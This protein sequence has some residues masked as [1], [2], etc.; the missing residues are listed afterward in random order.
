[1]ADETKITITAG[2]SDDILKQIRAIERELAG[3]AAVPLWR[4]RDPAIAA[5]RKIDEDTD[6]KAQDAKTLYAIR[7][8]N[9]TY[10]QFIMSEGARYNDGTYGG[11]I[12]RNQLWYEESETFFEQEQET[13]KELSA[14]IKERIGKGIDRES[15]RGA[16]ALRYVQ[17]FEN[18]RRGMT[19]TPKEILEGY[20]PLAQ[21]YGKPFDLSVWGDFY[22]EKIMSVPG[23]GEYARLT[24]S[25]SDKEYLDESRRRD[26]RFG[27]RLFKRLGNTI[28]PDAASNIISRQEGV[29]RREKTDALYAFMTGERRKGTPRDFYAGWGSDTARRNNGRL[30]LTYNPDV[31]G[32]EGRQATRNTDA[33]RPSARPA[34]RAEQQAASLADDWFNEAAGAASAA[35]RP[36]EAGGRL[37]AA[38]AELSDAERGARGEGILPGAKSEASGERAKREAAFERRYDN[39]QAYRE[40]R[41]KRQESEKVHTADD[42]FYASQSMENIDFTDEFA[43]LD[44]ALLSGFKERR[45][46]FA[47]MINQARTHGGIQILRNAASGAGEYAR[48]QGN[49]YRTVGRLRPFDL[50]SYP[51]TFLALEQ[52]RTNFQRGIGNNLMGIGSGLM[53]TGNPIGAAVGAGTALFGGGTSLLGS[54]QGLDIARAQGALGLTKNIFT[55]VAGGLKTL[56]QAARAAGAGLTSVARQIVGAITHLLGAGLGLGA[57]AL[58][59]GAGVVTRAFNQDVRWSNPAFTGVSLREQLRN[60]HLEDYWYLERGRLQSEIVNWNRKSSQFRTQGIFENQVPTALSGMIPLLTSGKTGFDALYKAAEALAATSRSASGTQRQDMESWFHQQ[61]LD[62]VTHIAGQILEGKS[63]A[64]QY[65]AYSNQEN[66]ERNFRANKVNFDA[67]ERTFNDVFKDI[68]NALWTRRLPLIGVTGEQVAVGAANLLGSIPAALRGDASGLVGGVARLGGFALRGLDGAGAR[69]D[70]WL[71]GLGFEHPDYRLWR[72]SKPLGKYAAPATLDRWL[73]SKPLNKE[74]VGPWA[75]LKQAGAYTVERG[76]G[77]AEVTLEAINSGKWTPVWNYIA[78]SVKPIADAAGALIGGMFKHGQ[79]ILGSLWDWTAAKVK[80][81]FNSDFPQ[82]LMQGFHKFSSWMHDTLQNIFAEIDVGKAS[83]WF[84]DLGAELFYAFEPAIRFIGRTLYSVVSSVADAIAYSKNPFSFKTSPFTGKNE[85]FITKGI[86]ETYEKFY[87][88]VLKPSHYE[89]AL[90]GELALRPYASFND[91]TALSRKVADGG[92]LLSQNLSKDTISYNFKDVTQD[93]DTIELLYKISQGLRLGRVSERDTPYFMKELGNVVYAFNNKPD[94]VQ[95]ELL[96]EDSP[97]WKSFRAV[98]NGGDPFNIAIDKIMEDFVLPR[99]GAVQE[100]IDAKSRAEVSRVEAAAPGG[101]VASRVLT[102]LER[103]IAELTTELRALKE[104]RRVPLKG[105]VDLRAAD[106]AEYQVEITS[107]ALNK[108]LSG[109]RGNNPYK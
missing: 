3:D 19:D 103:R 9:E 84:K 15:P 12:S 31:S 98:L 5:N 41:R 71:G 26:A 38:R 14:Y 89:R 68:A 91:K 66:A 55:G 46:L 67:I 13:L 56:L 34:A 27:E 62:V 99:R 8:Y 96:Q 16:D 59:A 32:I 95:K 49:A 64:H 70:D 47:D 28:T 29:R 79:T 57:A 52:Q 50:W 78:E 101:G 86:G 72:R 85:T 77:L 35:S 42:A 33:I 17:Q 65:Y 97:Y 11:I 73:D 54:L 30:L 83:E 20:K 100:R 102:E 87:E 108:L 63:T 105:Y 43:D 94:N 51:E 76:L 80:A 60:E 44:K 104:E 61:G 53:M 37:A 6:L 106:G 21:S 107:E 7:K 10:A 82:T 39:A 69:L 25:L 22:N 48:F 58:G 81:F 90:T 88:H 18:I 93:E 75:R 2:V 23:A 45:R 109:A 36:R 24:R 1:M 40:Y 4:A 74:W 92:T